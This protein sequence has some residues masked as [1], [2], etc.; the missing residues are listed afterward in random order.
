MTKKSGDVASMGK[1]PRRRNAVLVAAVVAV[2]AMLVPASAA[3]SAVWNGYGNQFKYRMAGG[4]T[5]TYYYH[6]SAYSGSYNIAFDHALT[7][8]SL[9]RVNGNTPA[10]GA[11]RCTPNNNFNHVFTGDIN[12]SSVEFYA[13]PAV[14]N[15][16]GVNG[17]ASF[18]VNNRPYEVIVDPDFAVYGWGQVVLNTKVMNSRS[19]LAGVGSKRTVAAHEVGHVLGL[20]HRQA[21]GTV[22]AQQ[23]HRTVIGPTCQDN[24]SLRVRW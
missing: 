4:N 23:T 19:L 20:A 3:Q 10:S 6:T 21:G 24:N 5:I 7:S 13:I 11:A 14:G 12:N 1:K 2:L 9:P 18:F 22:M 16:S 8:W 15:L 17:Y